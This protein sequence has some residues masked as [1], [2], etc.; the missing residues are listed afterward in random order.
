M[1]RLIGVDYGWQKNVL[2]SVITTSVLLAAVTSACYA[3]QSPFITQEY[4]IS[5]FQIADLDEEGCG[6]TLTEYRVVREPEKDT[7][8]QKTVDN[9]Q[10]EAAGLKAKP[11]L[12]SRFIGWFSGE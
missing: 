1:L 12:W 4:K 6:G 11:T 7:T 9:E 8:E 5:S 2:P 3:E 10:Q